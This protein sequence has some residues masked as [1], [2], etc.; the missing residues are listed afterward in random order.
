CLYPYVRPRTNE[1]RVFFVSVSLCC[2]QECIGAR[3]DVGLVNSL[4][5]LGCRLVSVA[6]NEDTTETKKRG[7]T[8][9]ELSETRSHF[10]S[11][12]LLGRVSTVPTPY[13]HITSAG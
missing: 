13:L 2:L 1:R 6:G 4:M 8:E 10:I 11:L 7:M 3:L 5:P 9:T 12:K